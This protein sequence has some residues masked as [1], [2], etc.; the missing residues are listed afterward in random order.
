MTNARARAAARRQRRRRQIF[1]LLAITTCA[2][3][4]IVAL[5]EP[6]APPE[7][8]DPIEITPTEQTT[9]PAEEPTEPEESPVPGED[10]VAT[11]FPMSD[12]ERDLVERVV[13][14]E[15]GGETYAG[16]MAVAQCI[17]NACTHGTIRPGEA[18]EVYGYASPAATASQSVRDAVA[19]VFDTGYTVTKEPIMFFYA[20]KYATSKWHE[21]QTFVIELGD[22]RF[23]ALKGATS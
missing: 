8:S 20:P 16:Q 12:E 4:L 13:M 1:G 11:C 17:L 18:V 19:A 2:I 21:S 3:F 22:H 15:A 10:R 7:G 9:G 6:K 5:K 14:A 23:F